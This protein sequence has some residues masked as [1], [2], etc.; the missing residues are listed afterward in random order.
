MKMDSFNPINLPLYRQGITC[1]NSRIFLTYNVGTQK[2]KDRTVIAVFSIVRVLRD[3]GCL[4][5]PLPDFCED[6]HLAFFIVETQRRVR[7]LI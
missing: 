6:D 1:I 3:V 2:R 4:R 7:W 5:S